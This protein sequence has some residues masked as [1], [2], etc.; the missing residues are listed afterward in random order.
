MSTTKLDTAYWCF[1]M[2]VVPLLKDMSS[3]ELT[4]LLSD[5]NKRIDS[6]I[7]WAKESELY[8]NTAKEESERDFM[9]E[10]RSDIQEEKE[11]TEY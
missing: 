2:E 1:I 8:R 7:E 9:D 6:D 11:I 4:D 3:S 5:I 10:M